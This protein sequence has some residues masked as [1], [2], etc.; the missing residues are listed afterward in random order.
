MA[1]ALGDQPPSIW[2]CDT[3]DTS[4]VFAVHWACA[5][6][7][8]F[9]TFWI[10]GTCLCVT[11]VR[12]CTRSFNDWIPHSRA[13][14]RSAC[15]LPEFMQ[16]GFSSSESALFWESAADFSDTSLVSCSLSFELH[17]ALLNPRSWD[18][19]WHV[20]GL[21]KSSFRNPLLRHHLDHFNSLCLHNLW[22]R[23]IHDL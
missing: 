23:G 21:L 7:T 8:V 5:T 9:T 4:T 22:H 17:G 3:T 15:V 2:H 11:T 13:A 16:S 20:H 10:V 12:C 14:A 1:R 6:F 19:D 18:L